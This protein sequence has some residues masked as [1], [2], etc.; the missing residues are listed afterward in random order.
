MSNSKKAFDLTCSSNFVADPSDEICIIGGA[1]YITDASERGKYDTDDDDQDNPLWRG[2]R[3]AKP[4]KSGFM[5][6]V[7]SLGVLE[8][9]VVTKIP[10]IPVPVVVAGTSRV[11]AAR[12]ANALRA[13]RGESLLIRI[14]CEMRRDDARGLAAIVAAENEG[15]NDVDVLEKIASVIRDLKRGATEDDIAIAYCVDRKTVDGWIAFADHAT[16]ETKAAVREG[17]VYAT[18]A[19]ILARISDPEKQNTA[20]ASMLS[21]PTKPT[22]NAAR[23]A[24]A[25][26]TGARDTTGIQSRRAMSKLHDAIANMK[27]PSNTGPET[28]AYYKGAEEILRA[29]LGKGDVSDR[30]A[31][32]IEKVTA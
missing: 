3:L 10:G 22:A 30:L 4:L 23:K 1:R 2:T 21:A 18:N 28:F 8:P 25:K 31:T 16:P 7:N 17:R 13:S 29:V 20:L 6:N 32:L 11:R 15:R 12:A 24:V 9:I 19:A 14:K 27:L 26:A 5:L